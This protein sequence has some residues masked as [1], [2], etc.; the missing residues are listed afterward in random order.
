VA[1]SSRRAARRIG[2]QNRRAS[3]DGRHREA[4]LARPTGGGN[5]KR[6]SARPP[7]KPAQPRLPPVGPDH[8][9]GAKAATESRCATSDR[10]GSGIQRTLIEGHQRDEH[11]QEKA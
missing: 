11:R 5:R 8:G 4:N 9:R 2:F 1:V 6:L 10:F 7:T 3:S